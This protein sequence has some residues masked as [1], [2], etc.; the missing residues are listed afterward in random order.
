[1]SRFFFAR[2]EK[3][4]RGQTLVEFALVMPIFLLMVLG[5]I[6]FGRLM[7]TVS[8]VYSAAREA[9]RYGSASAYYRDC[10]GI[11]AAANRVGFIAAPLEI[12]IGYYDSDSNPN[13]TFPLPIPHDCP[14]YIYNPGAKAI[15][16][17]VVLVT[18]RFKFLFLSLPE[19]PISSQSVRTIVDQVAFD[20]EIDQPPSDEAPCSFISASPGIPNNT[21]SPYSFKIINGSN[22]L[23]EYTVHKV[24]VKWVA[25]SHNKYNLLNQILFGSS[26]VLASP[27]NPQNISGDF[28][29]S[30]GGVGNVRSTLGITPLKFTFTL[31]AQNAFAVTDALVTLSYTDPDTSQESNIIYCTL[32]PG[33]TAVN[34]SAP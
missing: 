7:A 1:M 6:E 24:K 5:V 13:I 12:K 21:S 32:K 23:I 29:W 34:V 31:N 11:T 16:R 19:F 28:E 20:E 30:D 26:T 4:V 9:A 8:S 33:Q 15:P 10:E 14:T 2:Q 22:P 25:Y 17:I 27:T 18:S 3:K